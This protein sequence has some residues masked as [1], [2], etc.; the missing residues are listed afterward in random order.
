MATHGDK[1]KRGVALSHELRK[2]AGQVHTLLDDGTQVTREEQLAQL[3]WNQALGWNEKKRDE[4]G[5]LQEIWHPPVAWAQ[6]YL[7][8]R[9]EGKAQVATGT[10]QKGMTAAEK[11]RGLAKD[12]L[13]ALVPVKGPPAHR[14]K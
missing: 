2:L 3:I 1:I 12:R 7:F 14:P 13:N 9:I 10:E 8:E 11:V 6:Q 4:N 5:T